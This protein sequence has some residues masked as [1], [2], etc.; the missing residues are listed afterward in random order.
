LA[1]IIYLPLSKDLIGE[2]RDM[3]IDFNDDYNFTETTEVDP[4]DRRSLLYE[5]NYINGEVHSSSSFKKDEIWG[6][7]QNKYI[8]SGKLIM[9]FRTI[10][11]V[12]IFGTPRETDR[13]KEFSNKVYEG[14]K[15]LC[16]RIETLDLK[17]KITRLSAAGSNNYNFILWGFEVIVTNEIR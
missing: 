17:T 16:S 3:Y 6:Y 7:K 8:K 4:D 2:I 11:N 9:N 15:G 12:A 10:G 1:R 5:I 13:C 14:L